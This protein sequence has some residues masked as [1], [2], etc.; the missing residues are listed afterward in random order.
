MINLFRFLWKHFN[1]IFFLLLEIFCLYL[2][3]RNN[4]FQ[5][6]RY[7]S[8]SNYVAGNVYATVTSVR[9]YFYLK[10]TNDALAAENARLHNL[11]RDAFARSST[12]VYL[13][14][15]S[16]FK[17]QYQYINAKIIN[18]SVNKR[19]NYLTLDRGSSSGIKAEMAVISSNGIVG[20]TKD[21]SE[22]FTSVLSVLNKNAKISAKIKK[23]NYFG[24]LSWDG[25]DYRL[26]TLVDIPT[27]VNIA[28]GDTIVT[29]AYSDIFPEN[30]LIGKIESFDIKPGDNFYTI[31]VR[32]STN[33]K[34]VTHVY[35]VNNLIKEERKTLEEQSQQNDK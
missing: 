33:F 13:V 18:N 32:Y 3:V 9:E 8:S 19:N 27:H 14:R 31:I 25:S 30:I 2:V 35:V 6:A 7:V 11:T 28:I 34:N 24:S 1:F 10:E 23:N 29:N 4:T 17:Q 15:D 26:G 22:N 5:R 12:Q 21:V 16:I 20:I